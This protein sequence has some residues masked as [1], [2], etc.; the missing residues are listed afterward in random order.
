MEEEQEFIG[1]EDL[2]TFEGWLRY[3][4]FNVGAIEP[5]ELEDWRRVFE[6]ARRQSASLPKVGLMKLRA[7]P[8]E[9]RYAVA[10]RDGSE[11]W[12]TL[13]VRR[14]PKGEFFVMLPRAKG[15]PRADRGWDPHASYH[16]RGELHLKT[17]GNKV[18]PAQHRQPLTGEFRGTEHLGSYYGHAPK[19]IGA[20]CNAESFSG[21]VE[22]PP[23]L[24]GPK[25]GGIT[26]DLVEPGHEP[27]GFPWVEVYTRQVF[28]D[29]VPWVVITVG[30]CA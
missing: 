30:R 21:V 12:L 22:L 11:L 27:T 13:W 7:I 8:G 5:S 1:E 14:S 23:G 29:I 17:W 3:Q 4:G 28:R 20:V 6:D 26:V 24:L 25:D 15:W 2:D 16:L 18:H 9:Y 10:V 19:R